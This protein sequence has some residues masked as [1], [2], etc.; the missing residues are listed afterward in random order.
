MKREIP[1]AHFV[2][3]GGH[4]ISE[5]NE[6][7][8]GWIDELSLRDAVHILGRRDDLPAVMASFDLGVCSSASESFPVAVGELM[9][10][11]LPCVVTDAG[12]TRLLAGDAAAVVPIRDAPALARE[13]RVTLLMTAGERRARGQVA[14]RRIIEHFSLTSTVRA[15]E[16]LFDEVARG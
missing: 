8:M 12:D 9:A 6:T 5:Q 3:C 14:R 11:G 4:G 2:L 16:M 15:Y 7:L 1:E 10:S 13:C